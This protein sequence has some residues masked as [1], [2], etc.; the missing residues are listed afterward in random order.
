MLKIYSIMFVGPGGAGKTSILK[1]MRDDIKLPSNMTIGVDIDAF[2]IK[3][4]DSAVLVYDFGGQRQFRD[5][6]ETLLRKTNLIVLVFDAVRPATI[7]ELYSWYKL[8]KAKFP[9]VPILLVMNKI[10]L[11]PTIDLKLIEPIMRDPK[12]VNFVETT[13][14]DKSTIEELKSEINKQ[15]FA[16]ECV[17]AHNCEAENSK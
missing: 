12:V 17:Y 7:D 3:E 16:L 4:R 10:D 2:W 8:V 15:L 6:V 1:M 14:K 11:L 9:D 13:I 5:V